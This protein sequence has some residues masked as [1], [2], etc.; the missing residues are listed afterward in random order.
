MAR[1]M[2]HGAAHD[3]G[4]E[5]LV[6]VYAFWRVRTQSLTWRQPIQVDVKDKRTL[7][8]LQEDEQQTDGEPT[9]SVDL[10]KEMLKRIQEDKQLSKGGAKE[11]DLNN[12]RKFQV[13]LFLST[14]FVASD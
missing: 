11:F 3:S 10:V 1:D 2:G 8:R 12:Q 5:V 7:G 13:C 9:E 4:H 6:F 14:L